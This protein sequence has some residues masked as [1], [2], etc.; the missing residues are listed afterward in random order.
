MCTR[1]IDVD[2]DALINESQLSMVLYHV[3]NEVA[4]L[5]ILR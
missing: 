3:N 5:W 1:D 4:T 2:E